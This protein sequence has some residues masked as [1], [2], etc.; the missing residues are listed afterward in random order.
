[1]YRHNLR[2]KLNYSS[3]SKHRSVEII[4]YEA[5]FCG[6]DDAG[7]FDVIHESVIQNQDR[8]SLSLSIEERD[9]ALTL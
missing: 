3:C 9:A 2:R 6:T 4:N 8:A 7:T 5:L 1:M